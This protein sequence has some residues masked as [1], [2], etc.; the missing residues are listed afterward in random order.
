MFF[1]CIVPPIS[2][3]SPVLDFSKCFLHHPYEMT[4]DLMNDTDL[5]AKYE[6]IEQVW[7]V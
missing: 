4:M 5:P 1:R 6:L 2:L 3:L 7:P